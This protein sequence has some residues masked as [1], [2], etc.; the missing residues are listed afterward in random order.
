MSLKLFNNQIYTRVN[1][2]IIIYADW[3]TP[4]NINFMAL[5]FKIKEFLQNFSF[6]NTDKLYF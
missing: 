2:I 3:L 5:L 6:N 1:L 4:E